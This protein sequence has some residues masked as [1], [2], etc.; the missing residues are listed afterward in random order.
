MKVLR[1]NAYYL[2]EKTASTHLFIDMNTGFEQAGIYYTIITPIP[3]RGIDKK[4]REYYTKK[5]I[6]KT[7]NGYI[8]IKRFPL[9]TEKSNPV[10][11]AIRYFIMN[12][13][14]YQIA[15]KENDIDLV[16]SSSTP[17]TQGLLSALVAK[18]LSKKYKKKIPFVFNLQDVFPDSLVN[19]G[20]TK[21]G[22]L[23]WKIGRWIEDYTYNSADKIIV[24]SKGFKNNLIQKGVAKDKIEVIPNWIDLDTVIP[25]ERKNNKLI[26]E[27]SLDLN[28]F[29]IVYAGNFGAAQGA[30]IITGVAR[31]LQ[32]IEDIQFV[33]FGGGHY[34][35]KVKKDMMNLKN[36]TINKLLSQDRVSE[37][38]S[39]GDIALIT[40]KKGTG[41]SG[42]PSKLWSIM[43]CNTQIIASFDLNSDLDN[44]VTKSGAGVCVEPEN[45]ERLAEE[46]LRTYY[47][48]TQHKRN[49]RDYV[50]KNASKNI[51]VQRYID[52]IKEEIIKGY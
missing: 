20:M 36:V 21:K 16:F 29:I 10:L 2:P 26:E 51:C 24:I 3:S 6:E 5:T 13:K 23:S 40:C 9:I 38:Y 52:I 18:K 19:A 14:E 7:N 50:E 17:P 15:I 45:I 25:V 49:L 22:S 31:K 39:L 32:Y 28:K 12:L 33:I 27:L 37:V 4:T 44:I 35:E 41:N 47:K 34:F 48:R 1:L 42:M 11:R 8:T 43:A 46:I 30:D